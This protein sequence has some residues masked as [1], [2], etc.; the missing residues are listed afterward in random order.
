MEISFIVSEL[1]YKFVDSLEIALDMVTIIAIQE[2]HT[3][4]NSLTHFNMTKVEDQ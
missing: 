2:A 1:I 3:N 4:F